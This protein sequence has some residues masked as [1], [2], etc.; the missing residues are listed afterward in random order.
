V[1]VHAVG[2]PAAGHALS[3]HVRV[4]AQLPVVPAPHTWLCDNTGDGVWTQGGGAHVSLSSHRA[5]VVAHGDQANAPVGA[6]HAA[7]RASAMRKVCAP[8]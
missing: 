2:P 8:I 4:C 3:L 5:P 6:A 1:H 7:L